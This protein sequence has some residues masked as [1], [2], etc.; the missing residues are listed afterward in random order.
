MK[1]SS[2]VPKIICCASGLLALSGYAET[3]QG[4]LTHLTSKPPLSRAELALEE[5]SG[6]CYLRLSVTG[7]YRGSFQEDG[8]LTLFTA[9]DTVQIAMSRL[10]MRFFTDSIGQQ[11]SADLL[12]AWDKIGPQLRAPVTAAI[13]STNRRPLRYAV[14]NQ[15]APLMVKWTAPGSCN[16]FISGNRP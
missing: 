12:Y 15:R 14:N 9:R 4:N 8:V 7:E 10:R 2:K 13:V 3:S 11:L 5:E 1:R 6:Y 16:T